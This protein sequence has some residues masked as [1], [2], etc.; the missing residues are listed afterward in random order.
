M[1]TFYKISLVFLLAL[2][3]SRYY[4][5]ENSRHIHDTYWNSGPHI[6]D[7][8]LAD[9]PYQTPIF[10]FQSDSAGPAIL[11]IGGTHGNEPAGFEAAHRLVA[12]FDSAGLH[13]G[14]VYIIPEANKVAVL[15]K[16]RRIPVPDDMDHERGN[17]NRCYPGD[18]T[19]LPME[20]EAFEITQLVR[21]HNIDILLDL[22]ESPVFHLDYKED[23]GQYH[24]LGQTLIYTPNEAA[25]WLGMVV[26]DQINSTIPAGKKQFSLAEQPI[27]NSA[28]WLV[29]ERFNIPGFT[30]ET[31]KKLP[32]EERIGYQLRVVTLI[33]KEKGM[34]E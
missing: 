11:I 17:L 4:L 24:G 16:K 1:N 29:G 20:Q 26:L 21:D 28:A 18:S 9:T 10:Q 22:H 27:L 3:C 25:T 34:I 2:S 32:L 23:S 19:G 12:M 30:V 31:C 5:S 6:Y 15:H 8:L 33:L 13:C 7:Y 14:R